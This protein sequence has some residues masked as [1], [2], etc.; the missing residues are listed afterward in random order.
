M[1]LSTSVQVQLIFQSITVSQPVKGG[2]LSNNE[3]VS[4][5]FCRV[6]IKYFED[7]WTE[8]MQV[9]CLPKAITT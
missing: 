6:P 3:Y 1:H 8:A 9:H 2:L 5:V 4:T 7:G